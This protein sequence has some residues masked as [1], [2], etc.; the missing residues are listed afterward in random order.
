MQKNKKA[1][2]FIYVLILLFFTMILVYSFSSNLLIDSNKTEISKI[3][4][5]QKDIVLQNA[6]LNFD[7]FLDSKE[8]S[9]KNIL[10]IILENEKNAFLFSNSEKSNN[11]LKEIEIF[12]ENPENPKNPENLENPENPENPENLENSENLENPENS[13]NLENPENNPENLENPEI[14]E[15]NLETSEIEKKQ[16]KKLYELENAVLL[17]SFWENISGTLEIAQNWD[18]TNSQ[19]I[20]AS[21]INFFRIENMDFKNNFY[22]IFFHFNEKTDKK[23]TFKISEESGAIINPIK[24]ISK[25]WENYIEF[26]QNYIFDNSWKKVDKSQFFY[27]KNSRDF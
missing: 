6:N 2:V 15:N 24:K 3:I 21:N 27:Q 19:K 18:F 8:N 25:D 11:I 14:P 9:Q 10:W 16:T 23:I 1:S 26:F 7:H 5:K 17:F 4:S 12:E 13:E 22:S 20:N